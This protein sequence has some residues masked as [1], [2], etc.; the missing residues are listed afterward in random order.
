M[1]IHQLSLFLENRP[2]Q[3]KVPCRALAQAGVDIITS[4]LADTA[5]F[6]IFRIIVKD[7][8]RAKKVLEEAGSVVKVTEVLAIEVPDKPGGLAGV[9]E[10]FD[11]A[12]LGIEYMYAFASGRRGER[13]TCIF[14]FEDPDKAIAALRNRPDVRVVGSEEIL[15]Q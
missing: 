9:L 1:K 15:G 6:G 4:T 12:G 10:A 3:L 13:A 5:Q 8:E 7:W 14:R 11:V 2:G